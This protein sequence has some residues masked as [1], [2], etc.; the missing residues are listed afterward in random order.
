MWDD[1]W[2][3]RIWSELGRPWDLIVIGGGITGAGILREATRGGLRALLV[4]SHDFASGT[5][6]RSS[7]MV[8]GGFRYLRNAQIRM[9]YESVR[10]RE[11]LL[12]QGRGLI[13]PLGFLIPSFRGDRIPGWVFGMGLIIYD[14]LGLKWGHRHYSAENLLDLCPPL[15][16]Q[17]L[18]GGYR[19]FDAHTDDARL[20]LRVLR[21]AVADGGT[22]LNYAQAQAFLR[23][24]KGLVRGVLLRD[25]APDA[26]GR[27]A[28]VSARV[29]VN[30]TGAWADE[31]R[32]KVRGRRRLRPLRGSHLVF[33][34]HRLPLTRG[35]SFLHPRDSR[36]LVALPWEG[37]AL[38]GTTDVDHEAELTRDPQISPQEVEYLLEAAQYAFPSL[39][40]GLADVIST[41]AGIRPVVD[42]GRTDPSKESREHV[43]WQENGL[44]TVTGGKLT[45]FRVMAHDALR[46]LRGQLPGGPAF[47]REDPMLD[48]TPR[49]I[50]LETQLDPAER[51][52]L[53][54]RYGSE[55]PAL[56]EVSQP[57]ELERIPHSPYLWGE[58]RWAAR[59]EGVVHLDDLLLRRVRL[60]LVAPEGGRAFLDR[61]G[62]IARE[63]LGWDQA[64]WQAEVEAYQRLWR[65]AY[66]LPGS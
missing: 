54:G 5:S 18:L 38:V 6:S 37:M 16:D 22:A 19:Y 11:K 50:F 28:E 64:R 58:V 30:A 4:E 26:E 2:R 62:Q 14:L 13:D 27:T 8:H 63:E 36:P 31:M 10:E 47:D 15:R 52:R 9:T 3:D 65:R 43:L 48:E 7:K 66:S 21:E 34:L 23:S 61:I 60:G 45:T 46:Q 57:E 1:S 29:V 51:L 41:F 49:E 59:A 53:C 35:V 55:T 33:P 39:E 20:V 44:L 56:M 12:Q 40:L 24:Q 25:R 42:T 17:D 32:E